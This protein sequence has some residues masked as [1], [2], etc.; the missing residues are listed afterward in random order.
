MSASYQERSG[1]RAE[2]AFLVRTARD[3]SGLG[4]VW[5]EGL[6]NFK[7]RYENSLNAKG[8]RSSAIGTYSGEVKSFRASAEALVHRDIKPA[9]LLL[10]R[11]AGS[12]SLVKAGI[13]LEARPSQLEHYE[14]F[15]REVQSFFNLSKGWD[16]YEAEPPS[17]T[18]VK[19]AADFIDVVE[20]QAF[21]IDWVAPTTDDSVMVTLQTPAGTQE[22]DFYSD[23]DIAVT[24]LEASGKKRF[25]DVKPMDVERVLV[26]RYGVV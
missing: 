1:E 2:G 10:R 24:I 13:D 4:A 20:R 17:Q 12:G 18:A 11:S 9:N 26:A 5:S 22:W 25:L 7:A 16:S 8:R 14:K 3:R 6:E 15:R 21:K 19:N 23:G